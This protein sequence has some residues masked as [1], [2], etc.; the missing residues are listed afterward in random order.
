MITLQKLNQ[1]KTRRNTGIAKVYSQFK[2]Q[3]LFLF[4]EVVKDKLF[5]EMRVEVVVYDFCTTQLKHD[6]GTEKL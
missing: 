4:K 2:S 6:K 3:E 1:L 5:G